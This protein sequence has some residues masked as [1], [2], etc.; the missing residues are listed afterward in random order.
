MRVEKTTTK[1]LV[2]CALYMCATLVLYFVSPIER[3][4]SHPFEMTLLILAYIIAF[5]FGY[6]LWRKRVRSSTSLS[7]DDTFVRETFFVNN[8][9]VLQ[10]CIVILLCTTIIFVIR[11]IGAVGESGL[12]QGVMRA[13]SDPNSAYI[14]KMEMESN[15]LLNIITILGAPLFIYAS[16]LG[17]MNFSNLGRLYQGLF[18]SYLILESLRWI[19]IGTNKGVFD[20]LALFLITSFLKSWRTKT[21]RT[22]R[23]IKKIFLIMALA[24][25]AIWI[26]G[27]TVSS[28]TGSDISVLYSQGVTNV[29]TDSLLF[30][31]FPSSVAIVIL[32]FIGYITHGYYGFSLGLTLDWIPTFGVGSSSFVTSWVE[33]MFP[34]DIISCLYQTRIEQT[35]GWSA[36]AKWHT[37]YLWLAN[38]FG[39]LGVIL[40]MFALGALF[41]CVVHDALYKNNPY[42][43]CVA[44]LIMIAIVYSSSNNQVFG[45]GG[46]LFA[47]VVFLFLW[48]IPFKI[49]WGPHEKRSCKQK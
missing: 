20:I 5:A 48:K 19:I 31:V 27:L 21:N 30:L 6:L 11:N 35:Y 39:F 41:C 10:R 47:L 43:A 37:M 26:F 8:N 4:T 22:T 44:Y 34:I 46:T 28:R 45:I 1:P 2:L 32:R 13:L 38:D 29:D 17:M 23:S 3:D 24:Y 40:F 25:F 18:I 49:T 12:V 15:F 33:R 16:F 7:T 14:S 42:A 9:K 36:S